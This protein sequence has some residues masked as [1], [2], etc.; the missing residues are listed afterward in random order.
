[1]EGRGKFDLI[2]CNISTM[3]CKNGANLEACTCTYESCP[4]KGSCCDCVDY[5]RR[6]G[7]LPGCYFPPEAERTYDRS[8]ANFA[9][10]TKKELT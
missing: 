10:A 2:F 3:D 7:E 8:F 5:H 4:R 6:N 1:M 9:R